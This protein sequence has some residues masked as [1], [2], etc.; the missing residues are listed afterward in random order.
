MPNGSVI[1]HHYKEYMENN[2]LADNDRQTMLQF[3]HEIVG[4]VNLM[5]KENVG[6]YA[7]CLRYILY[8]ALSVRL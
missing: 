3:F 6:M 5:W 1:I 8:V 2:E 7:E 4:C